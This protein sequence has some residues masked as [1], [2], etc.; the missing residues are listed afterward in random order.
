M[1]HANSYIDLQPSRAFKGLNKM[2][3]SYA[4]QKKFN[5]II[6]DEEIEFDQSEYILIDETRRAIVQYMQTGI[7][8]R[9]TEYYPE[10]VW[11]DTY[12]KERRWAFPVKADDIMFNK[13][14]HRLE[15]ARVPY[16]YKAV[17][18]YLMEKGIEDVQQV[19]G[20]KKRKY[21]IAA[22]PSYGTGLQEDK[23]ELY[24]YTGLTVKDLQEAAHYGI[25]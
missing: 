24:K 23:N 25:N 20:S 15:K 11:L 5:G 12:G 17:F 9:K 8:L 13:L 18:D 2:F 21:E 1:F 10:E 19:A 16:T 6:E 7:P 4:Y 3:Q 22:F 14:A